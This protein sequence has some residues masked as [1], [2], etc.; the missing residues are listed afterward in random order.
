[1]QNVHRIDDHGAVGGVLADG[2]TELLDGLEGV[3]VQRLFP[4]VHVGRRPIAIDSSDSDLSITRRLH[5]H[6]RK[7]GWLG[8][9]A[10]YQHRDFLSRQICK[11]FISHGSIIPEWL[12]RSRDWPDRAQITDL[13]RKQINVGAR[14]LSNTLEQDASHRNIHLNRRGFSER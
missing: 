3:E 10:V 12:S 1:M 14:I 11:L 4:R 13:W 2:V 8:V 6:L 7:Q 5:Q 9:V